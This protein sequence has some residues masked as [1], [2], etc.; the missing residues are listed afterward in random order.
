MLY[1]F[2]LKN[3]AEIL[4]MTEK[5]SIEL[6]GVRPSSLQLKQGLPVFYK[7]LVSVLRLER[8]PTYPFS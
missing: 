5:K 3:Q 1:E 4:A 8:A 7:Q 2:L 6:A